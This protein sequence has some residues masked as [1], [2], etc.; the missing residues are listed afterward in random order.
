MSLTK[1]TGLWVITGIA[2]LLAAGCQ[3]TGSQGAA[4]S[5]QGVTCDK[6]KVTYVQVPVPAGKGSPIRAY[7]SQKT[8]ECPDC[9]SA[10]ENFFA[11]G[12]FQHA[13]K[14]CGD[15]MY[16]CESH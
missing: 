1:K 3:T 6:C 13:C 7:K 9:K 2:G 8:M 15:S 4:P 11:T 16:V 10:A 5:T 14:S 12:K